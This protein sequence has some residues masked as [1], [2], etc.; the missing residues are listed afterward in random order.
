[1]SS[2][3][4]DAMC[5]GKHFP[6]MNWEW[7]ISS[8]PMHVYCLDL[9]ETRYTYDYEWFCNRFLV[10]LWLILTCKPTPCMS[11]GAM[12]AISKIS[13]W[14]VFSLGAYIYIYVS[15]KESHQLPH[16]ALDKLVLLKISYQTY[17]GGF[18]AS[19]TRKNM[20]WPKLD[21]RR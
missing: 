5:G 20:T 14:Y 19:M 21:P 8:L 6:S 12:N 2:Y 16:Y 3:I 17:V 15:T 10:P 1:M 4:M 9:W 11:Q 7:K 13:D 18:G